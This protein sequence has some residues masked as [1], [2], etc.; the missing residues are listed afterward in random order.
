[1]NIQIRGGAATNAA[2]A[3][4]ARRRL[5]AELWVVS[6]EAAQHG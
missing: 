5:I 1:M 2:E 3:V 4:N 6:A